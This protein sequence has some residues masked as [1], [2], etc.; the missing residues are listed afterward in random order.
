MPYS[1]GLSESFRNICEKAGVQVHF[2]G[3]NP[4]KELLVAPKEKD[5]CN[6]GG[7]IYR[8]R[9]DHQGYTMEYIGQT[10]RNFGDR[11]KENLRG[12]SP[13]VDHSQTTGHLKLENFFI[14]DRESQ[15]I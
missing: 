12:L 13:I 10:G 11:H 4:V 1:I 8:Y 15:G 5:I 3:S 6:K 2:K 9:C 7:V 14:V